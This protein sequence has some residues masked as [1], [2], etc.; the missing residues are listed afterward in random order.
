MKRGNP[1][2]GFIIFF[3]LKTWSQSQKPPFECLQRL[4]NKETK[5]NLESDI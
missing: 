5:L 3:P 2:S 1:S 4:Q